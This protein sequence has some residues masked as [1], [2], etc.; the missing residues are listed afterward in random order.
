MR[1]ATLAASSLLICLIL[2]ATAPAAENWPQFRG[3]TGQ[4]LTDAR[5]LPLEWCESNNITWKTPIHGKAWSSPVIWGNQ[6]WMTTASE[7]GHE[8]SVLTLDKESGK[9]IRD[10][11]V[12]DVADPQFCHPFNSYASPTPA[13]E[14]GR[15]YITYGSP[16]TACLDTATG[17]VLWERRDFVCNHFRGSGSSLLIWNDLLIYPFDGITSMWSR[18]IRRRGRRFGRRIDR[19]ISKTCSPTGGRWRKG[20]F[21]RRFP[22]RASST[23]ARG[24]CW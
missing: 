24:R 23:W 18:W 7:D 19:S 15:I 20:I 1:I 13:I 22:R 4:G 14:E 2:A 6:I 5:D 10:Q 12:F 3:P 11:K 16:G 9:I 21:G 17:K 8:L